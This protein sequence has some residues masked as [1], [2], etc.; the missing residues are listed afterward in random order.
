[1]PSTGDDGEP[2]AFRVDEAEARECRVPFNEELYGRMANRF[3]AA[4]E[5]Y[6][7]HFISLGALLTRA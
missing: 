3:A 2:P 4:P 6:E 7:V 5:R 1:L